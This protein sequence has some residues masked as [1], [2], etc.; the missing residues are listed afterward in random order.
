MHAFYGKMT[1][2]SLSMQQLVI[3]RKA[4]IL[5]L[6]CSYCAGSIARAFAA[7]G[8]GLHVVGPLGLQIDSSRQKRAGLDYWPYVAVNIYAT[9]QVTSRTQAP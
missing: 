8:V 3:S 7:R 1:C 6:P 2:A 5:T 4:S 9:W